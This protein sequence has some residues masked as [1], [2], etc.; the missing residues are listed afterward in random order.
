MT[1]ERQKKV[2]EGLTAEQRK[3][4]AQSK[5]ESLRPGVR[6][7]ERRLAELARQEVPPAAPDERLIDFMASLKVER[8]RQGLSLEDVARKTGIDHGSIS[9]IENGRVRNPT[10]STLRLFARA[11]GCEI[12]I[13]L[14]PVEELSGPR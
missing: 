3:I 13:S 11:L 14:D 5:A 1:T 12:A 6:E 4:V 9:K 8:N 10:W 2:L 7:E